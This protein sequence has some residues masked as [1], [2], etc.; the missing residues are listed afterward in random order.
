MRLVLRLW[1][2]NN[3]GPKLPQ[4][5]QEI[6]VHF[7][8]TSCSQLAEYVPDRCRRQ[9]SNRNPTSSVSV[10]TQA[11]DQWPLVWRRSKNIQH[12]S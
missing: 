9:R 8:L 12:I 6:L 3:H 7:R 10:Y 5:F 2:K 11:T 1:P 4:S